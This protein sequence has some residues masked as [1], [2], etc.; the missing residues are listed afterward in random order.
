M[1]R[2]LA[3]LVGVAGIGA[4]GV[5]LVLAVTLTPVSASDAGGGALLLVVTGLGLAAGK[6]Y[7]S[8]A[9][10]EAVAPAPWDEGGGLVDGTP[11]ETADPADVTGDELAALVEQARE[12]ARESETVEEG[13]AVVRPPLRDAL[14][15][16][17]AAGGSDTDDVEEALAT[18]AWTDDPVAAAVV[19]ERVALPRLSLRQRLRAWLF[20]ERVVRRGTARAVAAVD[21]AA[22]R[23][24]P[25]VVGRDAPRTVPTLAPALGGLQRAADGRLQRSGAAEHG[26]PDDGEDAAGGDA[27]GASVRGSRSSER[28]DDLGT[29]GDA[30]DSEDLLGEVWDDA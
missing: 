9:D 3:G 2:W 30:E 25:S 18:G 27:N 12:R 6:L 16:V 29:E 15:R 24:L 28:G 13:F 10:G 5:G 8:G 17:L 20:P 4:I 14:S 23:E 1:N 26:E 22:E 19:D 11:E 7:R 21:E